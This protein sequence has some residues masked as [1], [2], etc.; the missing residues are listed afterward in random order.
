VDPYPNECPKDPII[1]GTT[2][3]LRLFARGV[4]NATGVVFPTWSDYNGQDDVVYYAATKVGTDPNYGGDLWMATVNLANHKAGNH[5]YGRFYSQALMEWMPGGVPAQVLLNSADFRRQ[6]GA[7]G[8][9]GGAVQNGGLET[10]GLSPWLGFGGTQQSA[11]TAAAHGGS[12]SIRQWGADGG[13]YQDARGLIPGQMYRV[14]AWVRAESGVANA[15]LWA[16][17]TFGANNSLTGALAISAAWQQLSIV[18][19]ATNG[20]ALRLHLQKIG[21]AGVLYWDDITVTGPV[22]LNPG[23]E[24]GALTNWGISNNP[25]LF[26]ASTAQKFAGSYAMRIDPGAPALAWADVDG[27][28]AGVTYQIEVWLKGTSALDTGQVT[29][30]DTMGGNV[31][32]SL[33]LY[34]ADQEWRRV[35]LNYTAN[36]TGKVR[37]KLARSSGSGAI[38]WDELSVTR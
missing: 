3:T 7:M 10:G 1:S 2:G 21:S 17:D 27:V 30:D 20:G 15:Q 38:Y 6:S 29:L 9:G 28:D 22:A 32:Q 13:M 24:S 33:F 8:A 31:V 11:S 35:R 34:G 23:F 18:Y 26:T 14:K 36:G 19:T 12:Y 16:H 25:E 5:Y 4:R 37:V